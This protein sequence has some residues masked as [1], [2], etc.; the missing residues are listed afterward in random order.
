MPESWPAPFARTGKR[1][2]LA[3]LAFVVVTIVV[4]TLDPFHFRVPR[5][6]RLTWWDGWF[7]VAANIAL[8]TVPGF[9]FAFARQAVRGPEGDARYRRSTLRQA[10]LC[11]IALSATIEF[12]QLFE[13]ARY[14]S[15]TD[16]ATN[17]IGALLGAALFLR[18][19]NTLRADSPLIGMFAL[20]M[21]L[22]GLVYLL[23]P[24]TL[25]A[26]LTLPHGVG[27]ATAPG[28]LS[29]LAL[30]LF[31]GVLLGHVQRYR[32]GPGA[33][34]RPTRTAAVAGLG[35]GVCVLPI[36]PYH[37]IVLVLGAAIAMA[38]TWF[39]GGSRFGGSIHADRR[40]EAA[41]LRRAAPC[42]L[43]YLVLT[44]LASPASARLSKVLILGDVESIAAFTVL[45]FLLAEWMGRREF[46]FRIA[47]G[48]VAALCM[49][50]AIG[51]LA[52]QHPAHLTLGALAGLVIRAVSGAYGGWIYHL[53]RAHIQALV[54]AQRARSRS[55]PV[56]MPAAA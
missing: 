33:L 55:E 24:L 52:V 10:L 48:I 4:V 11:G 46:R 49:A 9:L 5:H 39:F 35:F 1:L 14:S 38:T 51:L 12:V 20:E 27:T 47:A 13:P 53:Q 23:V 40:F 29:L 34:A 18:V 56:R 37:P 16:V 50:T 28:T 7:D 45:G 43:G 22:M 2:G 32:L 30:A 26:S 44:A 31:L 41:A 21:P 17:A 3:V 54:N 42:F 6:F 19:A 25:L 36:A 8:F 15:L